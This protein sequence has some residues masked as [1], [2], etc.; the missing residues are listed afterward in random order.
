[1]QYWFSIH[2]NIVA[3]FYL[4]EIILF[5]CTAHVLLYS[6]YCIV[7]TVTGPITE[8]GKWGADPMEKGNGSVGT[9]LEVCAEQCSTV[10]E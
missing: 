4:F 1:M 3:F 5:V 9:S 10:L 6:M 7:F 2:K 8:G